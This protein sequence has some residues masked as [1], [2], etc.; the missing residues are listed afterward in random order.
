MTDAMH[1]IGHRVL[2]DLIE[3]CLERA[4]GR[5]ESTPCAADQLRAAPPEILERVLRRVRSKRRSQAIAL[6]AAA[7]VVVTGV[8]IGAHL[9]SRSDEITGRETEGS[10]EV[11]TESQA[12]RSAFL[13]VWDGQSTAEL[14]LS[15][16][17]L[18]LSR[19]TDYRRANLIS[20]VS[21]LQ[22]RIRGAWNECGR[23]GEVPP[24]VRRRLAER[25]DQI[26]GRSAV[27]GGVDAGVLALARD[28]A[29][30]DLDTRQLQDLADWTLG[31]I[32]GY[33]AAVL[34]VRDSAGWSEDDR[35]VLDEA[36]QIAVRRIRSVV[37]EAN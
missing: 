34:K 1:P 24:D 4:R 28:P 35:K 23:R 19:A 5:G 25:I 7:V 13:Q 18:V 21:E 31:A 16:L 10:G 26:D 32:R 12:T 33:R 6:H 36:V 14:T 27:F 2:E 9:S 3:A 17:M 8:A 15:D 37:A 22:V 29:R 30:R 11:W 20:V